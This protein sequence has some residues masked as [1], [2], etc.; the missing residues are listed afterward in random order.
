MKSIIVK[1]IE[2]ELRDLR[3]GTPY[4]REAILGG[5]S[6]VPVKDG[7]FPPEFSM[8]AREKTYERISLINQET[9]ER[10]EYFVNVDDR[11]L[12]NDLIRVSD[13]FINQ[14]IGEGI[15]RFRDEFLDFELPVIRESEFMNGRKSTKK[16]PFWKRLL[17]RY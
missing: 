15:Q 6:V 16:L 7:E 13:G 5:V 2:T 4:Y 3:D 9:K 14:K 1:K 17:K 10:K 12:W 11:H 8:T